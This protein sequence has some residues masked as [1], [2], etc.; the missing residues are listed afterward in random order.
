MA[1]FEQFGGDFGVFEVF[2]EIYEKFAT[3][4]EHVYF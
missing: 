4:F 1:I 2:K 3:Q